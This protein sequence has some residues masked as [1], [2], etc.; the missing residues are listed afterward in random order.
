MNA[1]PRFPSKTLRPQDM[2]AQSLELLAIA[3]PLAESQVIAFGLVVDE[4]LVQLEERFA[5]FVT[6]KSLSTSL[7]R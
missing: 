7:A 2:R 4:Q 3:E 5:G 1:T 6:R